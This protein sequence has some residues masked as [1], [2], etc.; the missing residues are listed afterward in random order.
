MDFI[1][2]VALLLLTLT[3]PVAILAV[4]VLV[5]SIACTLLNAAGTTA[6]GKALMRSGWLLT[7]AAACTAVTVYGYGLGNTTFGAWTDPDDRCTLVRPETDGFGYTGPDGGSL[8]LW[9]L[10]DTTCG[11]DLVPGFVNPLVVGSTVLFVVLPMI[12]VVAR[13]RL[14]ERTR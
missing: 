3:W 9:P 12:I 4:F 10:H 6:Q 8:S 11:P 14:R 2:V 7:A 5:I 13:T 1:F